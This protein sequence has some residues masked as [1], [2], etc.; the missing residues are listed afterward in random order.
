M[1][2]FLTNIMYSFYKTSYPNEEVGRTGPSPSVSVPWYPDIFCYFYYV[3]NYKIANNSTTTGA[4][5]NLSADLESFKMK[6]NI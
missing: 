4:R 1:S 6:E 5:E 2:S 3:K